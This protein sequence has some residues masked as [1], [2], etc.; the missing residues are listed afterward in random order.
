MKSTWARLKNIKF[1]GRTR[2]PWAEREVNEYVDYLEQEHPTL[3]RQLEKTPFVKFHGSPHETDKTKDPW[4]A[5]AAF[6]RKEDF[7]GSGVSL[8]VYPDGTVIPSKTEFPWYQATAATAEDVGE[9]NTHWLDPEFVAAWKAGD[10]TETALGDKK[11]KGKV[12]AE[13]SK[14]SSSKRHKSSGKHGPSAGSS[15]GKAADYSLY[16]MDPNSGVLYRQA[17]NGVTVYLDPDTQHEFYYD[18]EGQAVWL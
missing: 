1:K 17:E 6:R 2:I 18:E 15:K 8:H 11:G 5:S 4:H 7:K 9:E 3:A 12:K 10:G 14:S 16:S 13:S